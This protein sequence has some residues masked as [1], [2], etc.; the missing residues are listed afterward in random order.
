MFESLIDN[1]TIHSICNIKNRNNNDLV[2]R[3]IN[4]VS[5]DSFIESYILND[6]IYI[7]SDYWEYWLTNTPAEWHEFY[8]EAIGKATPLK[9]GFSNFKEFISSEIVFFLLN[10]FIDY[11]KNQTSIYR[12]FLSYTG[13]D[14]DSYTIPYQDLLE[15]EKILKEKWNWDYHS[16]DNNHIDIVMMAYRT[17]EYIRIAEESNYNLITHPLRNGFIKE[18]GSLYNYDIPRAYNDVVFNKLL[19]KIR[20]NYS[21]PIAQEL[22]Q[23]NN[24][25]KSLWTR[26]K[27]PLFSTIV[28]ERSQR[29]ED[30]FREANKLRTELKPFREKINEIRFNVNNNKF[31]EA[32]EDIR[33]LNRYINDLSPATVNFEIDY[34]FQIGF[35][36]GVALGI[37]P[38]I[39][40]PKYLRIFTD[41]NHRFNLPRS[42]AV[43]YRRLFGQTR[44]NESL[45]DKFK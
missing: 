1:A 16:A 21:N 3:E 7:N 36:W 9:I 43:S 44:L 38:K 5:L 42:Y 17:I 30:I 33:K 15:I 37:T 26:V 31:S 32:D 20:T 24:E 14:F 41:L 29:F 2:I 12:D 19:E 11:S 45:V 4:I 22:V 35:P 28:Y 18:I 23:L 10:A 25:V 34:T 40:T 8:A 39:K 27:M 13:R 6:F